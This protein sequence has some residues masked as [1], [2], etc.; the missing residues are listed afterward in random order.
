MKTK[1]NGWCIKRIQEESS[2]S[3]WD[4]A[5]LAVE[6]KYGNI[7]AVKSM[8][9]TV[10]QDGSQAVVLSVIPMEVKEP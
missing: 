8:A 2:D 10:Q 3:G 1:R 7:H 9:M 4:L 6:D 5:L